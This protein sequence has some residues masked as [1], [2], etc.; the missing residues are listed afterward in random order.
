V[1]NFSAGNNAPLDSS[2]RWVG[3]S[4]VAATTVRV[5]MPASVLGVRAFQEPELFTVG[6]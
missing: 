1:A 2:C 4:G 5:P 6:R 3:E